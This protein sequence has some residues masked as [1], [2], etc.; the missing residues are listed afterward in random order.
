MIIF[1]TSYTHGMSYFQV[2]WKR[3]YNSKSGLDRG[4]LIQLKYL[5][6]RRDV[7]SDPKDNYNACDDFITLVVTSHFLVAAMKLLGIS[8]LDESPQNIFD[9]TSW[10]ATSKDRREVFYS[11]CKQVIDQYVCLTIL[12]KPQTHQNTD[13]VQEYMKEVMTLGILYLNYKDSVREGDGLRVLLIWKFLL[14]IFQATNRR[15]YSLEILQSL[16]KYYYIFSPREANQFLWSRFINTRG[17]PGKNIP[18]D[19]H[20][21][22]CNRLCKECISGLGANQT[23]RYFANWEGYWTTTEYNGQL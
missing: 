1:C 20:L 21:E 8:E 16:Y 7:V 18:A 22:H 15:N 19:L 17:L 23:P 9:E 10:M 14:P 12:S 11:F 5:I 2:I 6:N 4:T 13:H 3:L